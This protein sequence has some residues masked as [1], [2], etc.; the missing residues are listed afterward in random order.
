VHNAVEDISAESSLLVEE[1]NRSDSLQES[2]NCPDSSIE[3]SKA[4]IRKVKGKNFC[5]VIVD[6]AMAKSIRLS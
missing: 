5:K 6:F 1:V 3:L 2:I 4:D